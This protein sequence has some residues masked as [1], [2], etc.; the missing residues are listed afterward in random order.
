MGVLKPFLRKSIE[1]RVDSFI[2][3][4]EGRT[5]NSVEVDTDCHMRGGNCKISLNVAACEF[6]SRA[7]EM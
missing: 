1:V 5:K 6:L 2:V 7:L 3:K 4:G